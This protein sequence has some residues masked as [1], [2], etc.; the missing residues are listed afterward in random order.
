M[1]GSARSG[2]LV[3][4]F[5]YGTLMPGHCRWS[6]VEP[7]VADRQEATVAGRLYDTGWDYPAARF[8]EAGE[9]DGW[10]LVLHGGRLAEALAELDEVEGD[11]YD[12]VV[13][14]TRA[15]AAAWSY[16]WRG[17]TDLLDPLGRRWE[18]V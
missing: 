9:I 5:V 1:D 12:R 4:L 3:A 18:G 8:D 11:E 13:V 6:T 16:A 2:D 14:T 15:G 17:R 7:F 10:L